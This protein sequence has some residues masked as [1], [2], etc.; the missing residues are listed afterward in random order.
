SSIT[1]LP[2]PKSRRME[3]A[4]RRFS[5][6]MSSTERSEPELGANENASCTILFC[7]RPTKSSPLSTN[8]SL[9]ISKSVSCT[10]GMGEKTV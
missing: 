9:T 10:Y 3:M 1:F 4:A 5:L 8:A 7:G 2:M 6:Q